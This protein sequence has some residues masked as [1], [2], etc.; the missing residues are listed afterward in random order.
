MKDVRSCPKGHQSQPQQR[1]C[2]TCGWR[3]PL[4]IGETIRTFTI[5]AHTR[6]LDKDFYLVSEG[7]QTWTL[8]ESLE[9]FHPA[10]REEIYQS[11]QPLFESRGV[12][13]H[14][15]FLEQHDQMPFVY[16]LMDAELWPL[17]CENLQERL[18]QQGLLSPAEIQQTYQ[19]MITFVDELLQ[20]GFVHPGLITPL[21]FR[22]QTEMLIIHEWE[23]CVPADDSLLFPRLYR[24]YHGTVYLKDLENLMTGQ[25]RNQTFAAHAIYASLC[26]LLIGR[27][28]ILWLP[29]PVSIQASRFVLSQEMRKILSQLETNLSLSQ[30]PRYL[31]PPYNKDKTLQH[32]LAQSN[33]FF[34]YAETLPQFKDAAEC[35]ESG[36]RN[37]LNDAH[38]FARLAILALKQDDYILFEEYLSHA[39]RIEP[40]ACFYFQQA[41]GRVGVGETEAA[42]LSLEEALEK[43][44]L[45][46]EAWSMLGKL[47]WNKQRFVESEHALKQ[48]WTLQKNPR[49]AKDLYD[50]YAAQNLPEYAEPYRSYFSAAVGGKSIGHWKKERPP[51]LKQGNPIGVSAQIGDYHL[52]HLI[53]EKPN[54]GSFLYRA[55][56]P[57]GTVYIREYLNTD[58]GQQ[59]ARIEMYAALKIKHRALQ[60]LI[61]I[62]EQNGQHYLIYQQLLGESMEDRLKR[63][64]WISTQDIYQVMQEIGGCISAFQAHDPP[65]IHGDIKPANIFFADSGQVFLLDFESVRFEGVID[66]RLPQTFPY[67]PAELKNH[68]AVNLTSDFYSL[69]VTCLHGLSGI[70]PQLFFSF[71]ESS[72]VN[73]DAYV[74]FAPQELKE[75]L[76]ANLHGKTEQRQPFD[77]EALRALLEHLR[78]LPA[79]APPQQQQEWLDLFRQIYQTED[80][81]V[82]TSLAE[83][84]LSLKQD[85]LTQHYI[86]EQWSRFNQPEAALKLALRI[87]RL[88]PE[89]V[90]IAWLIAEQAEKLQRYDFAIPTLLDAFEQAPKEQT[91]LLML[92]RAYIKTGET[93]LGLVA[94]Q[95]AEKLPPAKVE[96]QLEVLRLLI[97]L[98]Q[99]QAV[100]ERVETLLLNP[101]LPLENRVEAHTILAAVFGQQKRYQNAL[102]QLKQAEQLIQPCSTALHFDLGL[103]YFH[104]QEYQQARVHL[105]SC[106]EHPDH[107][108][109]SLYYLGRS[110]LSMTQL[111][112]ALNYFRQLESLGGVKPKDFYF[113]MGYLLSQ[114]R[115]FNGAL[116]MY[117]NAQRQDPENP[118]IFINMGAV[119]LDLQEPQEALKMAQ[120][121]LT[122]WPDLKQAKAMQAIAIQVLSQQAS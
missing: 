111:N 25:R 13:L 23:Y 50:Y 6:L 3:F 26:E 2:T 108:A 94:Y 43:W 29:Q 70:F 53:S 112:E 84:I 75:W 101:R 79:P 14:Q 30:L 114:L 95:R 86:A 24:G 10:Y 32:S 41:K 90:Q 109:A 4:Q 77:E 51:H 103:T 115:D 22:T 83:Q 73:W 122:L 60:P 9:Y 107:H 80:L 85:R 81:T 17:D 76:K 1:I 68:F 27:S 62:I 34:H 38:A 104:L 96:V 118:I 48:A 116:E 19:W 35:L 7:E 8:T 59:R 65:L 87:Q 37:N 56:G 72:F 97:N 99:F 98:E 57:N 33:L 67:A 54:L 92:A 66:S 58:L 55:S 20:I 18:L 74:L 45:Y 113:Q 100:E 63:Q 15:Y 42:I 47:Y 12:Q 39:I 16:T 119:F 120:H 89:N 40:L 36:V 28:P 121:A 21:L 117:R 102:E 69:A 106:I 52:E 91:T 5:E 11:V 71:S 93:R 105:L 64:G 31:P 44:D 88:A 49:H 78:A 46:P 61:D 110:H 82:F